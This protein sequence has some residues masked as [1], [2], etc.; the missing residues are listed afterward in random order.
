V[1]V[2]GASALGEVLE[3]HPDADVRVL[4][5]WLPVLATD[6]GPPTDRVRGPLQDP[7]VIEYWDP[8]RWA[9]PRMMQRANLMARAQGREPDFDPDAI[10]W[11]LI[12]LFPPGTVWEEPFPIPS[13]YGAPVVRSMDAV[14]EY[15]S[16]GK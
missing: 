15:L 12:G 7:R 11:D 14:D 2:R 16:G 1:C 10:A 5:I 13:W 4:V 9:S 3:R 8:Q 6:T